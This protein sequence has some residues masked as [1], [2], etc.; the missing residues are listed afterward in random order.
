M[1]AVNLSGVIPPLITPLHADESIDEASLRRLI[2]HVIDGGVNGVF[3]LG[4]SGEGPLLSPSQ[5]RQVVDIAGDAI[6]GRV[7]LLVGVADCSVRR[8]RENMAALLTPHVDAFVAT[9]PF[10]GACDDPATQVRFYRELADASPRPLVIY[11]IPSA[12]HAGIEPETIAR[13][14]S[15]PN[16]VGVKDPIKDIHCGMRVKL[17]WEDQGEGEIALPMFEPA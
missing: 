5:R 16:I 13:L 4:S 17:R 6:R 11:N 12:V 3:V 7:P 2:A 14:A 8:V 15:H 10:Y 9:L 1:R